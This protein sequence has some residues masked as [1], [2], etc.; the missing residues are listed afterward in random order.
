MLGLLQ[1]GGIGTVPAVLAGLVLIAIV[2]LV[3]RLVMKVAWRLVVIAIIAV[4]VLWLLSLL[5]FGLL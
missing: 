2:L 5:G 4:G 1:L 3:G